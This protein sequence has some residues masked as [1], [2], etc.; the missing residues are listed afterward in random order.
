[1]RDRY[2]AGVDT[3]TELRAT[4]ALLM[5]AA[6]DTQTTLAT[7]LRLTQGQISRKQAGRSEWTLPDCD[8]LAAHY[9]ITVAELLSG[10]QAAFHAAQPGIQARFLADSR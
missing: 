3:L 5:R 10:P 8:R 7:A 2:S 9:G 1:M 4:V 6:H